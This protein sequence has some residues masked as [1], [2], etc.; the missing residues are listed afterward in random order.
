MLD[1]LEEAVNLFK[2]L[3]HRNGYVTDSGKPLSLN[4]GNRSTGR[5]SEDNSFDDSDEEAPASEEDAG[6]VDL[7]VE[8]D[9]EVIPGDGDTIWNNRCPKR[10]NL[11]TKVSE[12][13]VDASEGD[14]EEKKDGA[15]FDE[16]SEKLQTLNAK[17]STQPTGSVLYNE[18][19]AEIALLTT[20]FRAQNFC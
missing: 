16:Y 17:L 6:D 4:G 9:V 12:T 20:N 7:E 8:G 11:K 13:P 19:Q 14:V 1:I 3:V 10:G 2:T 15:A 5:L 18:L